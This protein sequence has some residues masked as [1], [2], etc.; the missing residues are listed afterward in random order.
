MSQMGDEKDMVPPS[1]SSRLESSNGFVE[2]IGSNKLKD[3]KVLITRGESVASILLSILRSLLTSR[4]S[5]I[6]RSVT[7]LMAREGADITI[8]YL[9]EEQEDAN[10]TKE[11]VENEKR[12]CLLIRGDLRNNKSMQ[13][14]YFPSAAS[15]AGS[16]IFSFVLYS[17]FKKINVLVNNASQQYICKDFT[18]IELDQVED[19][20]RTNILQM[21]AI[22]KYALPHVKGRLVRHIATVFAHRIINNTSVVTFRGS[23]SMVDYA[24]TKGAIVGFTR[25]LVLQLTP[26]GIR[27]ASYS[28]ANDSPGAIYTPIQLDTRDPSS[29]EGWGSDKQLGR[30]GQPSEVAPASCSWL[31]KTVLST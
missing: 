4:S 13:A 17:R 19:L 20:F 11:L 24:S 31:A 10:V 7:V 8:V 1:E 9:P 3:K 5:G 2:Y 29:M 16:Q 23:S 12:S 30:P 18:Q 14:K 6:G 22:T 15:F 26:K 27:Y 28:N 25:S 21:F